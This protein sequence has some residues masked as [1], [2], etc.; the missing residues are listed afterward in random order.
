[1]A[2]RDFYTE[3]TKQV[4]RYTDFHHSFI[5]NPGNGQIGK[6]INA[7]CVKMAVRNLVLTDK[8][9]RP[10]DPSIG[11]N[12]RGSL[13]DLM[14]S[15]SGDEIEGWIRDVIERLEPRVDI[16]EINVDV[17]TDGNEVRVFLLFSIKTIPETQSLELK[18]IRDR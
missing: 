8:Y 16:E 11:C 9:E 14:H 4:E 7:D 3:T 13:F 2:R 1:M 15:S 17:N 5:P 12:V 6:K 18:L 10:G